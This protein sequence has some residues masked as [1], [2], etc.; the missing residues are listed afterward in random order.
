M[1]SAIADL[2]YSF[3]NTLLPKMFTPQQTTQI[4][5]IIIIIP[6]NICEIFL[7]FFF[8]MSTP[9]QIAWLASSCSWAQPLNIGVRLDTF[10]NSSFNL[11]ILSKDF[12]H[13]MVFIHSFQCN[14][15]T[16]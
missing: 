16:N 12:I 9:S 5:I 13:S 6:L 7:L 2:T 3:V 4:K 11:C 8:T 10:F 1:S 14:L 15:R